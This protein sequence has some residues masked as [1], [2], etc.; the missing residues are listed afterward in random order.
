M[1]RDGCSVMFGWT[2]KTQTESKH[3]PCRCRRCDILHKR[4]II[5]CRFRIH[6]WS[7]WELKTL[8]LIWGQLTLTD[9]PSQNSK[10]KPNTI[11]KT[12][13]LCITARGEILSRCQFL[14]TG[15]VF[16]APRERLENELKELINKSTVSFV[17]KNKMFAHARF[18]DL[19]TVYY[20]WRATT[21]KC[22]LFFDKSH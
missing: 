15:V 19:I 18:T 10:N 5:P 11:I 22:L 7:L 20:E 16:A 21:N 4:V 8:C 12:H 9:C 17:Q 2:A 13:N 14:L 1:K 6:L 3:S